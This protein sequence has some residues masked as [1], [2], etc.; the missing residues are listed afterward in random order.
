MAIRYK[1]LRL[2]K[3]D[4]PI[5]DIKDRIIMKQ[6]HIVFFTLNQMED[7]EKLLVKSRDSI[8]SIISPIK[9]I[10]DGYAP[11]YTEEEQNAIMMYRE[12]ELRRDAEENVLIGDKDLTE[13]DIVEL[14]SNIGYS[15]AVMSNIA[16]YHKYVLDVTGETADKV[17]EYRKAHIQ[18]KECKDKLDE[19]DGVL[20]ASEIE[21]K[22]IYQQL[23][24]N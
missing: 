22:A 18:Y 1:F 14:N 6:G 8:E 20:K 21:K 11:E 10:L 19:I 13:K 24:L 15:K 17:S 3:K 4:A 16:E 12:A 7:N 2:T 23:N 9:D 5:E